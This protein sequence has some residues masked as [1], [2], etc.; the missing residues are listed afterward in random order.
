MDQ[1]L[2][3]QYPDLV[4]HSLPSGKKL[5]AAWLIDQCGFKG[6]QSDAGVGCYENQALVLV[7]LK[8]ARHSEIMAWTEKIQAGVKDKFGV[9]LE[10][11]PVFL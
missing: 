11:E 8:G 9:V 3:R 6:M 5:A 4:A 10:R 7:N 2:L 1:G